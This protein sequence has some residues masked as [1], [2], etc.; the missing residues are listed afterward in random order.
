VLQLQQGFPAE[1]LASL[2]PLLTEAPKD[3]DIRTQLGLA[4]EELGD[5]GQAMADYDLALTLNPGNAL[6]LLYRGNLLTRWGGPAPRWKTI[7]GCSVWRP[8]YDEAWFRFG[9]ALWLME[10]YDEALASYAKALELNPGRFSAAFNAGTILLK[11]ERYDQ[12]FAAFEA[13]GKLAHDH[14]YLLGGLVSAV[15]GGC[16]F[17]R[18]PD[19]QE[20][21]TLAVRDKRAVLAPLSFLPLCDDGA[22]RRRCSENFVAARVPHADAPLWAGEQYGHDRIRIAYLSDDFRRHATAD[23]I[24]GLIERHDRARFEITAVSFCQDDGSAMRARLMRASTIS[25]TCAHKAMPRSR[26]C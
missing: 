26:D 6:T 15:E 1:A 10:R 16:D 11:L 22:L 24:A 12:A 7:S 2:E 25:T 5:R 8:G 14:P 3:A 21:A 9:G 13:A 17:S 18:W 23:L 20:R 19:I 4:R